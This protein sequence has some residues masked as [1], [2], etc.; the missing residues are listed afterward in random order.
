MLR[1]NRRLGGPAAR[2]AILVGIAACRGEA[3]VRAQD[4]G[5]E[6]LVDSLRPA[7]E[8]AVGLPFHEAPRSALRSRDEVRRYLI[9]KLDEEMPPERARRI[10]TGYRLFGLL[11]D[12][13][14]IRPLMLELLTE[15][16]VGFYDPDSA[17]LFGVEGGDPAQLRLVLAHE[18]VH[19]LQGQYIPLDSLLAPDRGNDRLSATQAV[20]EGQAT[21]ASIELLSPDAS[22]LD[23]PAF[24]DLYQSQVQASQ[25]AMPRFAAAPL[26]IREGLIFPYVQGARFVN[27]WRRNRPGDSMPWSDLPASTEQVIHPERYA[28]GDQPVRLRFSDS[29]AVIYEDG[30]GELEML[31]LTATA[32]GGT[33]VPARA[34]LGWGGDRYR[35][36]EADAGPALAWYAVF[37]TPLSADRFAAT[38]GRWLQARVRPGY[39]SEFGRVEIGG[40]PG[41]RW[42]FAP[43]GWAEPGG[44]EIVPD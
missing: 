38:T 14:A 21:L 1:G 29:V 34:P 33:E 35:I 39:A 24:W 7:V 41:V 30:L 8:A 36:V 10:E 27:W 13:V 22:V 12:S 44:V 17:M 28:N 31:V 9:A 5:I 37:D 32:A 15:Q 6:Q 19:A 11:P 23:D 40:R 26:V 16:V 2:L 4:A 3:P 42:V 18:M 20:L 43:A 25:S